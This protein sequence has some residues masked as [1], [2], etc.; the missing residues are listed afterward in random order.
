MN[1]IKGLLIFLLLPQAQVTQPPE[2]HFSTAE[3]VVEITVRS[4]RP[5]Q[6]IQSILF[7][8]YGWII[9]YEDPAYDIRETTDATSPEWIRLHPD[10]PSRA[11][12]PKGGLFQGRFRE[13]RTGSIDEQ[14]TL[15]DL[16]DQ[17]NRQSLPGFFRSEHSADGR[18]HVIGRSRYHDTTLTVLDKPITLH[19]KQESAADR[20]SVLTQEC[21][22]PGN[23]IVS[24]MTPM[25]AASQTLMKAAV[26]RGNC[27]DEFDRVL[28]ALPTSSVLRLLFDPGGHTS[29]LNIANA[30]GLP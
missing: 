9:D 16:V 3:G 26:A 15:E 10:N 8:K 5:W 23:S 22:E 11:L 4:M 2:T 25:N 1:C 7:H 12:D 24:G 28:N 20:L 29:Y 27:R 18:Y 17:Y 30:T 19:F 13:P 6:Q 21:S 14:K